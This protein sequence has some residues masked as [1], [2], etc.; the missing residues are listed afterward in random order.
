MRIGIAG[1]GIAG[2]AAAAMLARDGHDVQIFDQFPRQGDVVRAAVAGKE[3]VDK[4]ELKPLRRKP[5]GGGLRRRAER[6]DRRQVIADAG[7]D[8][9]DDVHA[10]TTGSAVAVEGNPET[11]RRMEAVGV[12][13]HDYAGREIS[14]KGCGGPTCLTRPILRETTAS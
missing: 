4:V 11:R 5:A 7:I 3:E 6:R 14:A 1:A 12:E 8:G 2:L 13:V 9:Y 10:M